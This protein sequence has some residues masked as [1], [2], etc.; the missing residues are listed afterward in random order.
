V[1]DGHFP[2]RHEPVVPGPYVLLS[3][4]D[5]GVGI[6]K[7]DLDRIFEELGSTAFLG[8]LRAQGFVTVQVRWETFNTFNNS[9]KLALD[10]RRGLVACLYLKISGGKALR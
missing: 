1:L 8:R 3:V 9:G 6:S 4:N 2:P 5:T 10:F 7:E